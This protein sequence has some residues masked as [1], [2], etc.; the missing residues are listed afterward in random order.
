VNE[1]GVDIDSKYLVAKTCRAGAL[2]ALAQF[3][4]TDS[5]HRKFIRWAARAGESARVC[6]E[7]TG[8]YGQQFALALHRAPRIEVMV[9]NPKAIR[10]FAEALLTRGKT[11]VID[12]EVILEYLQRMPFKAWQPPSEE[13]LEIQA[14]SRRL[15][16]L[17]VERTRE[18]NHLHAAVRRGS[19]GEAIAQD[20]AAHLHELEQRIKALRAAALCLIRSVPLLQHCY[21][22]L[23]SAAGIGPASAI[24]LIG[25]L[26][27]LPADMQ[28][29]QW[30]A[31]AGLD[32]RPH[33][34]GSTHKP[35]RISK[36]GNLYLREALYMPA[37]VAI[38]HDPNVNAF[39][40]KLISAGKK[41]LQAIV[42]VMRKLLQAL[43][44]MLKTDQDWIGQ[45]FYRL[46]SP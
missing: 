2:Q 41:P 13:V 20:I 33:E 17:T 11:D 40:T 19:V 35:R 26:M 28:A 22:R 36:A 24:K 3:D 42:A 14:L 29:P 23:I 1:I 32:P 31:H 37:L 30:V 6:C 5:G 46:Q 9:V 15:L 39:Y 27:M 25:E 45:K 8:V 44:G 12:A 7:S 10:K 43:W 21:E 38:K 4:N 34:S 18:R 16:Q